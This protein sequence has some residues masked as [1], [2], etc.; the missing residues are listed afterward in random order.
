M[1]CKMRNIDNMII[2]DGEVI[3][4]DSL[5]YRN[6]KTGQLYRVINHIDGVVDC[7]NSRD[8]E[9]VVLYPRNGRLFIMKY[10]EFREKFDFVAHRSDEY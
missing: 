6:K 1:N 9:E 4:T 2:V 5:V 3:L 7:T 10:D 8:G